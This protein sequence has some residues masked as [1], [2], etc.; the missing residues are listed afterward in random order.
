MITPEALAV[1]V[2][3]RAKVQPFNKAN[4]IMSDRTI[5][6][7]L[8]KAAQNSLLSAEMS[9]LDSD[10][11]A[12]LQSYSAAEQLLEKA[13]W[14]G[15]REQFP[16]MVNCIVNQAQI[17]QEADDL[18]E[19]VAAYERALTKQGTHPEALKGAVGCYFKLLHTPSS[20]PADEYLRLVARAA[21]LVKAYGLGDRLMASEARSLSLTYFRERRYEPAALLAEMAA[22]LA[23]GDLASRS[24]S[25]AFWSHSAWVHQEDGRE[26]WLS[27]RQKAKAAW[28]RCLDIDPDHADSRLGIIEYELTGR[29]F[30]AASA[31]A[32]SCWHIQLEEKKRV[33]C[34]WL[35]AISL[36]MNNEPEP[37]WKPFADHLTSADADLDLSWWQLT[38]VEAFLQTL[39]DDDSGTLVRQIHDRFLKIYRGKR[40]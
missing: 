9:K 40:H 6:E 24:N 30:A 29:E 12:A 38:E 31:Q 15:C 8:I 34:A 27:F 18:T 1:W 37:E 21:S 10:P 7:A 13:V 16:L 36:I 23:A 28:L 17:H 25:G 26:K 32:R 35:G 33:V 5:C 14:Q 4:T 20:L 22:D 39:P 11:R 19:A 3:S 2:A